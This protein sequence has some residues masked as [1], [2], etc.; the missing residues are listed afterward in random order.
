MRYRRC[1]ITRYNVESHAAL[2][3]GIDPFSPGW[4][5]HRDRLFRRYCLPSVQSQTERGFDW[6]VMF[7]PATPRG[8]I[9]VIEGV[10][11]A[12]FARTTNEALGIIQRDHND[13]N[14]IVSTRLDNDDAIAP[15]FMQHVRATIDDALQNGF[16]SGQD[17][18]VS[19]RNGIVAHAPSGRWRAHSQPSAPFLTLVEHLPPGQSWLSVLGLNHNEAPK[20]F[21]MISLDNEDPMWALMI[22]ERNISNHTLWNASTTAH[23]KLRS[24]PQQFPEYRRA[25]AP[26]VMFER[27][28]MRIERWLGKAWCR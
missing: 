21:P 15:D 3:A 9:E 1:L 12:V 6:F 5:E 4:M 18:L 27:T 10:G 19:Y 23:G 2:K 24:F 26:L 25:N 7:H 11:I 22:H 14:I 8:F 13:A 28:R 16:G 17:F 20:L